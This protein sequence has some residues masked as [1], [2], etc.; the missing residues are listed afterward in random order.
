MQVDSL[1]IGTVKAREQTL[2]PDTNQHVALPLTIK[3]NLPQKVSPV[4]VLPL[5]VDTIQPV[6]SDS[7]L[8]D[9]AHVPAKVTGPE[10]SFFNLFSTLQKVSDSSAVRITNPILNKRFTSGS[11]KF[12]GPEPIN[13][14]YTYQKSWVLGFAMVSLTILILMRIYFEKYLAAILSSLFNIQAAEKLMRDKNVIIRR[15]FVMLNFNFTLVTALYL[16]L[17]INYFKIPIPLTNQIVVFLCI[18]G[19]LILFLTFRLFVQN[20]VGYIFESGT[21]FK[22]L[23]HNTYIVNKNLGLFLLPLV[24]SVFYLKQNIADSVFYLCS[25]LIVISL[26]YRYLKALQIII[27]YKAFLFYSFLYLCTLEILPILVGIKFI[28]SLS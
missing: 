21:I 6:A 23:I 12:T 25:G 3:K 15:V 1:N 20:L 7:I 22:E 19:I 2:L 11:H 28:L 26:L 27:K 10:P 14:Q 24:I 4:K 16:Y 17:L 5:P 18:L 8:I 13:Y 9:S